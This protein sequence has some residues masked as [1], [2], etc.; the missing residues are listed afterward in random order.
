MQSLRNALIALA[1]STG[2]ARAQESQGS[3]DT[4]RDYASRSQL[5]ALLA[6]LDTA[7]RKD[8]HEY[9]SIAN[10]RKRLAEGDFQSGDRVLLHVEGEQQLA[11]TFTVNDERALALPTVG[12][13]SL[14]GVLR[15]ELQDYLQGQLARFIREPVMQARVLIRV[16][17]TGEVTRPGYYLVAPSSQ[18]EDVLM[19]AGGPTKDSHISGLTVQRTDGETWSGELI[20]RA[21][22]DG[23]SLDQL[24][25]RSGDRL[26]MPRNSDLGR[27]IMIVA[28]LVTIPLTI[29]T[30]THWH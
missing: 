12:S 5:E 26:F 17:V 14:A 1:L 21:I 19:A 2:I 13:I 4:R 16:G 6:R 7:N 9:A 3:W 10:I 11:D 15:S 25:L 22:A 29:M 30:L 18:I 27:T 8:A 23:K 28:A 24:G 20:Q